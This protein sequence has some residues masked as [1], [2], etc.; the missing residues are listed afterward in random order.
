M[1]QLVQLVACLLDLQ[2]GW[3][4]TALAFFVPYPIQIDNNNLL[5]HYIYILIL[6][7][8]CICFS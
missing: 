5:L 8:S 4:S 3:E 2:F 1:S 7:R 6:R